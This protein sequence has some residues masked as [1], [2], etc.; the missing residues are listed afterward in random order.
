MEAQLSWRVWLRG[1]AMALITNIP[2]EA[3]SDPVTLTDDE[4]WQAVSGRVLLALNDAPSGPRDGLL[5]DGH[6]ISLNE[7]E[8]VR[9]RSG[10]G[11]FAPVIARQR[12]T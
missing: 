3:W 1:C 8:V 12:R 4:T 5:L 6:A 11:V 10:G 7:G 2:S 9:Y